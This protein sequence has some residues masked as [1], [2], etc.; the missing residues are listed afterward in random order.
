MPISCSRNSIENCIKSAAC[1]GDTPSNHHLYTM[2]N[3]YA[4]GGK[5]HRGAIHHS[6]CHC[7]APLSI[8][9]GSTDEN[10]L[11]TTSETTGGIFCEP[12]VCKKKK[13]YCEYVKRYSEITLN[14]KL[15]GTEGYLKLNIGRSMY[16]FVL[17][18][19]G[20]IND[21]NTKYCEKDFHNL[22][23]TFSLLNLYGYISSSGVY[24]PL[25][26]IACNDTTRVNNLRKLKI[27]LDS[28]ESKTTPPPSF[29]RTTVIYHTKIESGN[30][31]KILDIANN[32]PE[33][34]Y[35]WKTSMNLF[36]QI[37]DNL[38]RRGLTGDKLTF[39]TQ[40][41]DAWDNRTD[42]AKLDLEYTP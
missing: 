13:H 17:L 39:F 29:G 14:P 6:Q 23:A 15:A 16:G 10:G 30:I 9:F 20:S 1:L 11:C 27:I 2:T 41:K 36:R 19:L 40:A 12:D 28:Y 5:V 22:N 34:H 32:M 4:T 37:L 26:F 18:V 33:L 35:A 21:S 31:R 25:P 24:N 7:N 3:L 38:S 8:D 42:N